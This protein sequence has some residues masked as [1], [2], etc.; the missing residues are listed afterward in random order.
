MCVMISTNLCQITDLDIVNNYN[1]VIYFIIYIFEGI[2]IYYFTGY[3]IYIVIIWVNL[4]QY[5]SIF[6]NIGLLYYNIYICCKFEFVKQ[7]LNVTF[8][9]NFR[10]F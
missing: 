9:T 4:A 8:K 1:Y 7:L 2:I 6:I 3:I 10:P 5:F